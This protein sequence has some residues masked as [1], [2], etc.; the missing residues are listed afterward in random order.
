MVSALPATSSSHGMNAGLT[1]VSFSFPC[2]QAGTAFKR[3]DGKDGDQEVG[4]V[5]DDPLVTV[6]RSLHRHQPSP[7]TVTLTLPHGYHEEV[8]AGDGDGFLCDA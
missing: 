1:S 4:K 2:R 7:F 6:T 3:R 8:M 5:H